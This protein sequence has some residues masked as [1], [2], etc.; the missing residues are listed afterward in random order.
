MGPAGWSGL[1]QPHPRM[2]MQLLA[3]FPSDRS[4]ACNEQPSGSSQFKQPTTGVPPAG[5]DPMQH[6]AKFSK[7]F[8][9]SSLLSAFVLC[10]CSGFTAASLR[11]SRRPM[12]LHV[13]SAAPWEGRQ[14]KTKTGKCFGDQPDDR[15]AVALNWPGI[16][17]VGTGG[18]AGWPCVNGARQRQT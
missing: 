16:L 6:A 15:H 11:Q 3:C 17:Y 7:P 10:N 9:Q 5:G 18:T 8:N 2:M 4:P 14:G 13:F 12:A 1:V